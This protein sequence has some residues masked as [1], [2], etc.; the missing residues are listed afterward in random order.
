MSTA[1]ETETK[2]EKTTGTTHIDEL[3]FDGETLKKDLKAAFKDFKDMISDAIKQGRI[4]RIVVKKDD[5]SV[6]E[7]FTVNA[8]LVGLT[9]AVA[10]IP[11]ILAVGAA[12]AL[13]ASMR[14]NLKILIE[15]EVETAPK[16]KDAPAH[17]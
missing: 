6:V 4:R 1:T 9:L 12:L 15:K 8:G 16:P 3:I 5:G 14:Y 17:V 13:A 10:L 2:T 7:S 11:F